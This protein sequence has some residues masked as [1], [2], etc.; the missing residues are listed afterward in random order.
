MNAGFIGMSTEGL[1]FA[2]TLYNSY[3]SK[4]EGIFVNGIVCKTLEY[5]TQAAIR[6]RGKAYFS[7]NDAINDND[8]LFVCLPDSKLAQFS[9]YLKANYVKNKILCHFSKKYDSSILSCGTT[10]SCYSINFPYLL[11]SDKPADLSKTLVLVEGSGRK[12]DEFM[13]IMSKS[14]EKVV[15]TT[16]DNRRL[17]GIAHKF[18]TVFLKGIINI[19]RHLFKIAGT[20]DEDCFSEEV[21]KFAVKEA[22]SENTSITPSDA[23]DIRKNLRV[24]SAINYSD[25]RELYKNMEYHLLVNGN[26]TP[27][28]HENILQ[29]LKR[30]R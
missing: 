22:K 15:F 18:A 29:T 1:A 20:Y 10:N 4:K 6:V 23:D 2:K 7:V 16:K 8:I 19:S 9:E 26:Y 25:T 24:L 30:K 27:D 13:E 14:L 12:D 5:T 3:L 21:G 11:S 17:T 28:E